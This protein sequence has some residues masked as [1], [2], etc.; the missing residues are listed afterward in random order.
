MAETMNQPVKFYGI[1]ET[2]KVLREFE[3][4]TLKT[5]RKDIRKIASPAV[6]AIKSTTPTVSPFSGR[7]K[8]GMSHSG[9][10][11][12]SPVS[13]LVS[14][15][16]GQKSKGLGSTTANL[17]AIIASGSKKQFGFNIVDMAGKSNNVRMSGTT[18]AYAYKGGSR[19]HSLNGQGR[20]L[21][22]NLPKRPSRYFYP[23]IESKLPR[24]YAETAAVIQTVIDSVNRKLGN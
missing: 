9:R 2:V 10:T 21:I 5:L 23:A 20:G 8:D 13:V 22:D 14:I 12:W 16:P 4:E 18:R 15:T 1:K 7:L 17:A 11:A 3:P 6:S 24:I 19:T